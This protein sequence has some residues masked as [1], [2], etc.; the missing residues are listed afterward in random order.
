MRRSPWLWLVA[1]AFLLSACAV[2]A[3]VTVKVREDGSGSV[4]LVAKVDA[5]AV[6]AAEVGG[7]T[8]ETRVRL[9]DFP[10]AGWAV[11][12]WVRNEDGSAVLTMRKPFANVDEVP[13]ILRELSGAYGPMDSAYVTRKRSF[14]STKY[15]VDGR[16]DLG[17]L[18]TGIADDAELTKSLQAQGVD[19]AG[20]DAQLLAQLQRAF[21]VRLVVELP[22]KAPVTIEPAAGGA[23]DVS[24][25]STVKDTSRMTLVLVAGGLLLLALV[26]ALWPGRRRGRRARRS[27]RLARR[28][29]R[30]ERREHR[31]ER[32][33][34][35]RAGRT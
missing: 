8:L 22:G 6:Q 16:I 32:R 18:G 19:V 5:E 33:N 15:A 25:S 28:A 23:A 9:S 21:S 2:D 7:G 14:F 27:R 29:H 34:A 30:H 35:K 3:T 11:D 13:G 12:P 26:V 4:E 31:N 20:V 1:L 24:V 17:K 10:T